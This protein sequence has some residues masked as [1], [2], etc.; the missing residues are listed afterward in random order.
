[1]THGIAQAAQKRGQSKVRARLRRQAQQGM[2]RV[3]HDTNCTGW[4]R[5][6]EASK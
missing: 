3:L 6:Q 2:W 4:P 5:L 1:M